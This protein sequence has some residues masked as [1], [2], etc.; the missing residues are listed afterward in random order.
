MSGFSQFCNGRNITI[1]AAI[2]GHRRSLISTEKWNMYFEDVAHRIPDKRKNKEIT[3]VDWQEY[4]S[5]CIMRLNSHV[6]QYDGY[7]LGRRV[8]GRSPRLPIGA[9]GIRT[10]EVFR[11]KWTSVKNDVLVKLREIQNAYLSRDSKGGFNLW[12]IAM[13]RNQ[14]T[15]ESFLWGTVYFYKNNGRSKVESEWHGPGITIGRC[16]G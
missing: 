9:V 14:K 8:F 12:L 16:R 13:F 11:I 5:M 4:A 10:L 6:H 3:T 2:R 1:H 7:T 15:E